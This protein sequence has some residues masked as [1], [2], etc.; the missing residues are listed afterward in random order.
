MNSI[1]HHP[2]NDGWAAACAHQRLVTRR[3]K[4]ARDA[5]LLLFGLLG[6]CAGMLAVAM[7][8]AP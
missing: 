6:F 2:R 3:V 5:A 4:Q 1:A 8:W 7:W